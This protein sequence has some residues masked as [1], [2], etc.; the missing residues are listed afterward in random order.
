[1]FRNARRAAQIAALGTL[2]YAD[3]IEIALVDPATVQQRLEQGVLPLNERQ[4][5]IQRLFSDA[6]CAAEEQPVNKRSANVICTLKGTSDDAAIV[7]GGHFD[8]VDKGQGIVDDWS[9]TSLLPSLYQA[10]SGRPRKHTFVFVAFAAEETGL[11]G[12]RRYVRNLTPDQRKNVRAFVNLEC[13]GLSAPKVW[14]QRAARDLV[15]WL[16]DASMG[17]GLHLEGVNLDNVGWDDSFPFTEK[18]I[19]VITVHSVT[20]QTFP[21]LHT[22]RDQV[23]AINPALYYDTYRLVSVYLAHLDGKLP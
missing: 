9:G 17:L 23:S 20:Q 14:L 19:P 3:N 4:E 22:A 15:T 18:K 11:N 7:V 16:Q 6:G 8:F 13:L 12:S 1:M 21:I 10:L 2:L 5:A